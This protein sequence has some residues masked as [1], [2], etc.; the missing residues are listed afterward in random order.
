MTIVPAYAA[1]LALLY[2][3]LSFRVIAVRKARRI[4]IGAQGDP[5]L[6]RAIRVHSNFAEYAPLALLLL[7]MLET[8]GAAQWL[9]HI[10]CVAFIAGRA[11]H[12][13]GM[14][15]E[16]EDLRF[17]MVGMVTTFGVIAITSCALLALAALARV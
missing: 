8:N 13:Y 2:V 17:R 6:E 1:L 12:A 4:A 10:L 14:S 7:F 15:H 11:S 9:V 3:Y 16:R 5:Q